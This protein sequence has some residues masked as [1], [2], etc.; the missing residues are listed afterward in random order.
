MNDHLTY[1]MAEIGCGF[2]NGRNAS[3]EVNYR[4]GKVAKPGRVSVDEQIG[5]IQAN[6]LLGMKEQGWEV[7]PG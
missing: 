7:V 6:G 1:N 2:N 4:G 5:V 3:V